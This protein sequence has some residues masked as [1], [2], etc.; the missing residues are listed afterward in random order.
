[1]GALADFE[2]LDLW[3]RGRG[4]PGPLQALILLAQLHPEHSVDTLAALSIGERDRLLLAARETVFGRRLDCF[5][6]CPQC[7][8]ELEFDLDTA[9]LRVAGSVDRAAHH[10]ISLDGVTVRFRLIDSRDL[11]AAACAGDAEQARACLID[12]IVIGAHDRDGTPLDGFPAGSAALC[13]QLGVLDPQADVTFSLSCD[14]CGQTWTG[15]IDLATFF[16][17]ELTT[18]ARRLL[19]EVHMLARAYGWSQSDILALSR[20]R[21]DAYLELVTA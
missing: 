14:T 12:R 10:E 18:R 6:R 13:A 11:V 1:M 16:W 15:F 19:L 20:P 2:L 3:E 17:S 5:T 7:E 9:A 8:A 4:K 21:R